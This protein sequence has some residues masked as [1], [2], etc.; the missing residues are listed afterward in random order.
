M[1]EAVMEYRRKLD[2]LTPQNKRIWDLAHTMMNEMVRS[3]EAGMRDK[4]NSCQ[5]HG[6]ASREAEN[7]LLELLATPATTQGTPEGA[8]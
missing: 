3:E 8:K 7:E 5:R 1:H 6:N 4:W 2:S